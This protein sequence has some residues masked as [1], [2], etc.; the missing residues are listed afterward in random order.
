MKIIIIFLFLGLLTACNTNSADSNAMDKATAVRQIK[1][2]RKEPALEWLASN[3]NKHPF[4]SNRFKSADEAKAFIQNLISL[5]AKA[6]FVGD[7]MDE[8]QRIA[9]EGGPYSA[10][11]IVNLPQDKEARQQIFAIAAIEAKKE[12]FVSLPPNFGYQ[13]SLR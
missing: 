9:R 10:T 6:V 13:D 5:G 7:P 1:N 2:I 4:A 3:K 8:T 12:G 11:L